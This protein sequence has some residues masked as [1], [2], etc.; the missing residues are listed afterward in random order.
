MLVTLSLGLLGCLLL[1]AGGESLVSGS[2]SIARRFGVGPLVI[3]LTVVAFGTSAPE[4]AVSIKAA[5]AG[6]GDIAIGNVVGS[7]IFNITVILGLAAVVLPLRVHFQIL[8]WDMPVMLGTS[9]LLTW[10]LATGSRIGRAE[11]ALLFAGI[12]AYTWFAVRAARRESTPLPADVDFT[13][14]EAKPI[15]T[16]LKSALLIVVGIGLLVAGAQML[17][18]AA[19]ALAR[20]AGVSEAVIG[21]TIVAAGTSL[22]ELVTSIVAAVRREPDLAVGNVV[23]SNIFNNLCIVGGASVISPIEAQ[24]ISRLDLGFILGT[25]ALLLPLLRTGFE[26]KRWE[27]ALLMAAYGVY[28]FLLWPK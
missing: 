18:H 15:A 7:N 21:L 10:M 28:L 8:R 2:S 4:L 25:A 11:G 16:P 6:Q 20:L 14:E 13:A 24:G 23:G 12:V 27:G 3:G 17:V 22:P 9:L 26:V 1:A 5:L 19:T